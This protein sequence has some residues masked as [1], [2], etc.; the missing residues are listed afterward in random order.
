MNK[1]FEEEDSLFLLS[2]SFKRWYAVISTERESKCV[3]ERNNL[4]NM[5]STSISSIEYRVPYK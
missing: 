2:S 3:D 1:I 5:Y 4:K